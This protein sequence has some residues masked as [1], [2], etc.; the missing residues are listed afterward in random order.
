MWGR[1]VKVVF[2]DFDG[3]LNDRVH[4][5]DFDP[6]FVDRLNEI[7]DATGANIVLISSWRYASDAIPGLK[8]AGATAPILG[9]TPDLLGRKGHYSWT[10]CTE[11]E[12]WLEEHPEVTAYV[13]LDDLWITAFEGQVDHLVHIADGNGIEPEHVKKAIE[14]LGVEE[15]HDRLA[16]PDVAGGRQDQGVPPGDDDGGPR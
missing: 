1:L 13:I 3:V 12:R 15:N 11:I 8:K 16:D 4:S 2:L 5:I 10:R 6:F 14:L 7:T 9:C